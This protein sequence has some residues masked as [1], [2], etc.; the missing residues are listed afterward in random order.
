MSSEH[1]KSDSDATAYL[2]GARFGIPSEEIVDTN[3]IGRGMT[4]DVRTLYMSLRDPRDQHE[5]TG[6]TNPALAEQR[7]GTPRRSLGIP[8]LPAFLLVFIPLFGKRAV[9]WYSFPKFPV[10]TWRLREFETP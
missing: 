3:A 2:I 6:A 1:I 9:A 10:G 5:A 8:S 4:V 7:E